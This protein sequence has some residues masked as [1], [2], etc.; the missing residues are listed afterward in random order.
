MSSPA[1]LDFP[2]SDLDD[3]VMQDGSNNG[4]GAQSMSQAPPAQ[5][6]FLPGTP[7]QRGSPRVPLFL[8]A[9][10]SAAGTPSHARFAPSS[11]ASGLVARRDPSPFVPSRIAMRPGVTT[12]QARD[13]T[14]LRFCH[15]LRPPRAGLSATTIDRGQAFCLRGPLPLP[16]QCPSP[17]VPLYPASPSAT[18]FPTIL[19]RRRRSWLP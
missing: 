3:A 6:L 5:S 12:R 18:I 2:S 11:P 14:Q 10:P 1:P 17:S 9:T 16:P 8:A 19:T 7:S 13:V 4:T 15:A